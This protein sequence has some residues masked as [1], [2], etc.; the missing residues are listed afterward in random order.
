MRANLKRIAKREGMT[1]QMIADELGITLGSFK[2]N[3][4]NNNP[5]LSTLRALAAVLGCRPGELID[6]YDPPA[7]A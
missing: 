5:K 4:Q 2:M 7:E 3:L 1:Y 6:P